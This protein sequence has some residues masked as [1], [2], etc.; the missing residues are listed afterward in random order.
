MVKPERKRVVSLNL[1]LISYQQAL[2]DVIALG[3]LHTPAYACFSNVHMTMEAQASDSFR[4]MVNSATYTLADGMP[5]V[6]ALRM[7]YGIRQDRIAG[8][9]FMLDSLQRCE[10]QQ[11]SVFLYGSTPEVLE[12]IRNFINVKFPHVKLAGIISPPFR[13]LSEEENK[14]MIN[15]INASGANIVF[16]GLGCPKQ[17]MWM[18]KNSPSINACLLGVGG[19]FEIHAGLKKRAPIWMRNAGLEWFYRLTLEPGRLLKRYTVT[20]SLFIYS[21]LRQY[22]TKGPE[23]K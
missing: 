5:L 4:D 15:Q 8:M 10:E 7:L 22:F 12:S 6:F 13:T 9:D 2:G 23:R 19:A 17:E 11:L 21:F 18:A 1:S 3:K 14:V 20:N 16:V